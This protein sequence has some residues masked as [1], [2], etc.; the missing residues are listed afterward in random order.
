MALNLGG[1]G[2]GDGGETLGGMSQGK[3]VLASLGF[4]PEDAQMN[5]EVRARLAERLKNPY[6]PPK[7]GSSEPGYGTA[8]VRPIELGGSLS[9]GAPSVNRLVAQEQAPPAPQ[10]Q[11]PTQ[12]ASINDASGS[13]PEGVT[14]PILT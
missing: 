5:P 13:I 12:P 6:G 8:A 9:D 10:R 11:R 14:E 7:S 4:D 3:G 1:W 2:G